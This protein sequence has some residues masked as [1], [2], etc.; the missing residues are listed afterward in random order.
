M[1]DAWGLKGV[2]LAIPTAYEVHHHRLRPRRLM[3]I[4][5]IIFMP[6]E[7]GDSVLHFSC[8]VFLQRHCLIPTMEDKQVKKKQKKNLLHSSVTSSEFAS[9][10]KVKMHKQNYFEHK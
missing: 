1:S 6:N 8:S 5:G 3:K 4:N 2:Q 10:S 9:S 7:N